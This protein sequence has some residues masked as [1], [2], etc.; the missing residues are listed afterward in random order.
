MQIVVQVNHWILNTISRV[1]YSFLSIRKICKFSKKLSNPKKSSNVYKYF[2]DIR[3]KWF[4]SSIRIRISQIFTY[5]NE[6]KDTKSYKSTKYFCLNSN[7]F[8]MV[9]SSFVRFWITSEK[10]RHRPI[11]LNYLWSIKVNEC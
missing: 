2:I 1:L 3:W 5:L 7:Y 4:R 6:I 8:S 11:L 9:R 10:S